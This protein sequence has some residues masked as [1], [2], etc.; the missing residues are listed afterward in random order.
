MS[1]HVNQIDLIAAIFKHLLKRHKIDSAIPRQINAVIEAA[2]L[3]VDAYARDSVMASP[4]MGYSAWLA[5]D[6]TGMS[7][8]FMAS[9]LN[10]GTGAQLAVPLD[11]DDFGRCVRMLDAVP[12]FRERIGRLRSEG[13]VWERLV[14]RWNEI[15]AA[16]RRSPQEADVMIKAIHEELK[17]W[18][19]RRIMRGL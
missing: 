17:R 1:K 4:N 19:R 5:S 10:G 8:L 12:S 6:D 13:P 11:A 15:E 14:D 7:S 2:N 3:I 18:R 9:T 16:Y